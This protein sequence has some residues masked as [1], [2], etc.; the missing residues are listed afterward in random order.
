VPPILRIIKGIV[1]HHTLRLIAIVN[2]APYRG[3]TP[4]RTFIGF[5]SNKSFKS[6]IVVHLRMGHSIAAVIEFHKIIKWYKAYPVG[7]G[8]LIEIAGKR[9]T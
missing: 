6:F 8:M 3:R 9:K 1:V 5:L 4:R 2:A 7:I